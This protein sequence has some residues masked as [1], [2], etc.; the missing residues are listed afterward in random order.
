MVPLAVIALA[1]R[2]VSL[3][4]FMAALTALIVL[5]G[6]TGQACSSE[7]AVAKARFPFTTLGGIV[8][9]AASF[10]LR[11]SWEPERWPWEGSAPQSAHTASLPERR[12]R[13]SSATRPA[14]RSM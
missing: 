7:W 8:A 14:V 11:P 1:V 6:E 10:A 5:L 3:G 4:L 13:F 2:A 9:V 12:W